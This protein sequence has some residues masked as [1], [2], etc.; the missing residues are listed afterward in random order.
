MRI[1]YVYTCNQQTKSHIMKKLLIEVSCDDELKKAVLI[2]K[3]TP[4]LEDF[5]ISEL[6]TRKGI[7]VNSNLTTIV[8]VSITLTDEG[9]FITSL[10]PYISKGENA[11]IYP[12]LISLG[13]K[14]R[15]TDSLNL[16]LGLVLYD[17]VME[18]LLENFKKVNKK[19]L[20]KLKLKLDLEFL[21]SASGAIK[22]DAI[23]IK[24]EAWHF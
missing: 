21:N 18:F 2:D 3:I 17:A 9:V 23:T 16:E 14:I 19:E 5:F 24:E 8:Q 10:P 11:R 12:V 20:E 7:A 6:L 1:T 15:K 13:E 4:Y 22:P